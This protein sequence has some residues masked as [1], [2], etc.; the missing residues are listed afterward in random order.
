MADRF[1]WN[2]SFNSQTLGEKVYGLKS[3]ISVY[4]LKV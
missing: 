3:N 2:V 1:K 4:K